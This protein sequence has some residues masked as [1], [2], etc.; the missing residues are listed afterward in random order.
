MLINK[1]AFAFAILSQVG[2]GAAVYILYGCRLRGGRLK[3]I[4]YVV[5]HTVRM[6]VLRGGCWVSGVTIL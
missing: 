6:Q 2:G 5:V 4:V 1:F 3:G